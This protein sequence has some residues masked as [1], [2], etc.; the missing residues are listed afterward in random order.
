MRIIFEGTSHGVPEAGKKCACT[1][2]EVGGRNYFI[3]A[4]CD[5]AQVLADKRI[6]FESVSGIF[7]THSHMDHSVG[8]LPFYA[9]TAWYYKES[10]PPV[11]VPG[12][13]LV[14]L[15]KHFFEAYGYELRPTQKLEVVREG[16][17]FDDGVLKVTAIKTMHHHDS[18]AF[19]VEAEGKRI[20]FSGDIKGPGI[21]FPDVYD[22]D[23]AVLEGAHLW[24]NDYVDEIKKHNIRSVYINHYGNYLGRPNSERFVYLRNAIDPI[25]AMLT[26]DGA[27]I[28]L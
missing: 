2:I 6:P 8:L 12:E 13:N 14:E 26:T 23:A 27:E 4:G 21:D 10:N 5:L 7:I 20:L 18:H 19:L 3:D 15:V 16:T 1:R 24:V 17:F 25:P 28:T 22:I 9:I 11:Y